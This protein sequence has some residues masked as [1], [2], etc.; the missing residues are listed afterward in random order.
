M[1]TLALPELPLSEWEDSKMTLHLYLQVIGKIQLQLNPRKNHWWYITLYINSRGFTTRSIPY[2]D[3][4]ESFE[5]DVNIIN[6]SLDIFT[7]QRRAK[8]AGKCAIEVAKGKV[9]TSNRMLNSIS[10]C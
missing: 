9:P 1:S 4:T 2:E 6:H 5:I 7:S 8:N 10:S 3:G